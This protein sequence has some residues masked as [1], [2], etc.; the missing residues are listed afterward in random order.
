MCQHTQEHKS[1]DTG[2]FAKVK[3]NDTLCNLYGTRI[4][5]TDVDKAGMSHSFQIVNLD[6]S[7]PSTVLR[8]HPALGT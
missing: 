6:R 3:V 8:T 5:H 2:R 1:Y 7:Q 4:R